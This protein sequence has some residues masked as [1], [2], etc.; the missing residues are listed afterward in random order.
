MQ[1]ANVFTPHKHTPSLSTSE[2]RTSSSTCASSASTA[3][4]AANEAR[5][6]EGAVELPP[7]SQLLNSLTRSLK[8]RLA[9]SLKMPYRV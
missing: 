4:M 9:L 3:S 1:D 6:E 7:I 8:L 5:E 2:S